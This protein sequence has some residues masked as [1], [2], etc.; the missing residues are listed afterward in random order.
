MIN[1]QPLKY[2]LLLLLCAACTFSKGQ[3]KQEQN[4]QK[5]E[6]VKEQVV[7]I[8]GKEQ[9]VKKIFKSKTDY[10]ATNFNFPVGKPNA[11]GYYNA[12]VFGENNHLGDDWN[13][14]TGGNSDLGDSIYT[15]ANGYVNFAEDIG[16]GW[17]KV[18]RIWHQK[19]NGKIVESLY[20]HC[21]TILVTK[22][23]YVKIGQKIATIGNADGQYLAHLHLEIRADINLPVGSGY[24]INK[25]GYIDPTKFIK[26]NR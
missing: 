23:Q 25:K 15:I 5:Q 8:V 11:K 19:P 2:T 7:P 6:Q 26:E 24:A 14:V 18:I 21:N 17:G 20:A 3:K 13:A 9:E 1:S 10:I 22:G 12:Q 4:K 16:G